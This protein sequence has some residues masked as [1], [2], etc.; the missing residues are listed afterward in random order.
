MSSFNL[1]TPG[2]TDNEQVDFRAW[3]FSEVCWQIGGNCTMRLHPG[4]ADEPWPWVLPHLCLCMVD[5]AV[6]P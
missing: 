4:G 3:P 2:M 6:A 5:P 1:V